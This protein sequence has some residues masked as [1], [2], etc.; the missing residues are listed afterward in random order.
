MTFKIIIIGLQHLILDNIR[1]FFLKRL[2][3]NKIN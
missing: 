1:T 3:R 2:K